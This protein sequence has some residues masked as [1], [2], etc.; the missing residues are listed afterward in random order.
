VNGHPHWTF[1]W[2]DLSGSQYRYSV[3]KNSGPAFHFAS[4]ARLEAISARFN[5]LTIISSLGGNWRSVL[6]SSAR[7]VVLAANGLRPGITLPPINAAA[8]VRYGSG[9]GSPVR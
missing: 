3:S 1:D 7:A 2:T 9:K 4:K 5:E 8:N 6:K